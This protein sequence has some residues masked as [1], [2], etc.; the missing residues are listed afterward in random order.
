MSKFSITAAARNDLLQIGHYT[1]QKWGKRQERGQRNKY[2]RQLDDAFR[3]LARRPEIG[4][5]VD[6]IKPEYKQL[7][8]GSHLIFYKVS[9]D[10]QIVVVRILHNSMDVSRRL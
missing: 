2:L 10:K 8:Q 7:S 9:S 1:E 6:Q 4:K 5:A 3:L